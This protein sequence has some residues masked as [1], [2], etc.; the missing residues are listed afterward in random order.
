LQERGS[1]APG[2]TSRKTKL[3][4]HHMVKKLFQTPDDKVLTLLRLV[5]AVVFLA[6]GSQKMFGWFGGYGFKATMGY[7]TQG[8][9]I[10]AVFAF[11]AIV[12]EFFGGLG[13]L[14]GLLNRIAAFGITAVML[15]AIYMVHLPNGF[16]MNWS[17]QQ[18]G[19]GFEYH[20][21]V[22]AMTVALMVKGA[23]AF[24][25]DRSISKVLNAE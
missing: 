9:H 17:G 4:E 13:L 14:L 23:G 15:V 24:S 25:L 11:L 22:L 5:L 12:A 7:F 2:R 1:R 16:F 20:L 18:K 19:E 10:P 8:A 3:K 6:H 21:L